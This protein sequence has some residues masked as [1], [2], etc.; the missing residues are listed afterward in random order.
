MGRFPGSRGERGEQ[1]LDFQETAAAGARP[2]LL[3]LCQ[4]LPYPPDGGCHIRSY[5]VLRLLAREFD[6]SALFFYRRRTRPTPRD[7]RLGLEGMRVLGSVEAFPIPQEWS[8]IRLAWDHF[9]SLATQRVYTRFLHESADFS[10]E[11]DRLLGGHDFDIVHVDSLDL[12]GYLPRLSHLPVVLTHHNVESR[13][14]ARRAAATNSRAMRQYL[15]LQSRLT[16]KEE[17]QWCGVADLNIVVSDTDGDALRTIVDVPTVTVP[18][19]VDTKLFRPGT[20]DRTGGIVF[21]GGAWWLPNRDGMEYFCEDILP[22]IRARIRNAPVTW[23]G[24]ASED[25]R[26]HFLEKYDVRLTG[27]VDSVEP[28][29]QEAGCYVVPLR[30]GGGTRLKILD[31]WAMAAPVVSTRLGCEG[32]SARDGE[33]ILVRDEPDAFA[34]AVCEVLRDEALRTRLGRAGRRTAE[35]RFDWD[36]IGKDMLRHYRGLLAR[37]SAAVLTRA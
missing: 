15:A 24:H 36:V 12:S 8:K 35:E 2:K 37:P 29:V 23:V 27:Y 13:L 22:R 5:N 7:V 16:A 9:R 1:D 17:R 20:G 30:I 21:V 3:F 4:S 18:N 33:D 28:F 25:D 31:A 11:L 10:C 6:V 32:L 14:L 19:G 26:H 34:S